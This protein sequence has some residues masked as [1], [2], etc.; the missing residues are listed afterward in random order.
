MVFNYAKFSKELLIE[1]VEQYNCEC[2]N[3]EFKD[4]FH[5]HI[6]TGNI[7]VLRDIELINISKF[8]S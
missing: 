4:N 8:G 1:N 3:S 2:E 7:E 5:H 6:V